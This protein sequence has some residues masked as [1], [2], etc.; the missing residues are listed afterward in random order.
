MFQG[1]RFSNNIWIHAWPLKVLN[2]YFGLNKCMTE[3]GDRKWQGTNEPKSINNY[4]NKANKFR[5]K[6][7]IGW[8][9]QRNKKILLFI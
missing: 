7:M 6:N 8:V 4:W 5:N 1:D 2:I 3:T 9:P